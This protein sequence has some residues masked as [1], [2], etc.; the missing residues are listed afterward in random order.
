MENIMRAGADTAMRI[1]TPTK[2]WFEENREDL[3]PKI[4]AKNRI[5]NDMRKAE[6]EEK[7]SLKMKLREASK[8]VSHRIAI[9]KAN[10]SR[11]K[12][13]HIHSIC[14]SPNQAWKAIKELIA[15]DNCHHNKPVTMKMKM[16]NG[17]LA[18]N[19]KQNLDVVEKHLHKVYNA[20][21]DRSAGAAKLIKQR[22][23]FT[24]LGD[25]I[26]MTEF[27]KAIRKLKNGKAPG[28]TGVPPDAF[29]CLEGENKR[30]IFRYI[31]DF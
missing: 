28:I 27:T 19:N 20:K 25:Q 17:E 15:G 31:V 4:Q 11:K 23:E 30:Q 10:W 26:L 21:R 6:G 29:K 5:L 16:E 7:D 8:E 12:A 13:E 2:G 3:Q 1:K 24:A 18:S 22:E 9:A 14:K